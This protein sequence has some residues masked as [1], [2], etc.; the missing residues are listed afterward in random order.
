MQEQRQ[1]LPWARGGQVWPYTVCPGPKHSMEGWDL[2]WCV[3][4]PPAHDGGVGQYGL[5]GG[6]TLGGCQ[7]ST[8]LLYHSSSSERQGGRK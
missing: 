1:C 5:C 3:L 8:Q 6:L 7:V 4:A 2:I